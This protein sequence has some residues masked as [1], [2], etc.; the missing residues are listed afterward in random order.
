M[1]GYGIVVIPSSWAIGRWDKGHKVLFAF[2]PLRFVKYRN[3][4]GSFAG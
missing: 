2:G 4:T 3:V 1:S